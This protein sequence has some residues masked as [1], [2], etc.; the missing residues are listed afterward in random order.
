MNQPDGNSPTNIGNPTEITIAELADLICM[1]CGS[2]SKVK[3][4]ELPTDDPK[5]RKPDISRIQKLCGWKPKVTLEDGL[6]ETIQ[7]FKKLV[8]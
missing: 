2:S 7:Y 4:V 8:V 6:K 3:F 5:L 1:L